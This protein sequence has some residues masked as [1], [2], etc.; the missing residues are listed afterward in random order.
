[1]DDKITRLRIELEA[2]EKEA[3]ASKW[4][5]YQEKVKELLDMLKGKILIRH[6]QNGVF[7]MF[8][9]QSYTEEYY[10]DR[11]GA[12]GQWDHTGGNK[13]MFKIGG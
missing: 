9:V 7:H 5:E 4:I 8:R 1:M 6:T 3:E 12:Y 10:A 11:A 13:K 2:A